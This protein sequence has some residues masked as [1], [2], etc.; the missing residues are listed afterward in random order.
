M[1]GRVLCWTA[2]GVVVVSLSASVFIPS[3]SVGRIPQ[4]GFALNLVSLL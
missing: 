3:L 4:I 1:I 2:E